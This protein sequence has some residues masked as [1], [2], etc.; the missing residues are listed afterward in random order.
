MSEL[1][2]RDVHVI[3]LQCCDESAFTCES[4][5]LLESGFFPLFWWIIYLYV[6]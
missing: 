4:A 3:F 1:E 6:Q 5:E 2:F